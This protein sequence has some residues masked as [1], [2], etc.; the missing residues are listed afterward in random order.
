MI[1]N[2]R[3][4]I[5]FGG[6]GGILSFFERDSE[7]NLVCSDCGNCNG[8]DRIQSKESKEKDLKLLSCATFHCVI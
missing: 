4:Q 1:L 8:H 5:D 3:R 6:I 2:D 7:D